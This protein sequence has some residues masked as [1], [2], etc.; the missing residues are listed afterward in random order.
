[1]VGV[2]VNLA[3]R[4]APNDEQFLY[5]T[6]TDNNGNWV[7]G[8][9]ADNFRLSDGKT[10]HQISSFSSSKESVSVGLLIDTSGSSAKLMD[11]ANA[12]LASFVNGAAKGTEFFVMTF[13]VNPR[14]LLDRTTDREEV[15]RILRTAAAITPA[16][17][18]AIFDA[19]S[20][21]VDRLGTA[22]N[23]KRVLMVFSDGT[24]NSSKLS[25][26]ALRRK[27]RRSDVLVYNLNRMD[28]RYAASM[29]AQQGIAF[30]DDLTAQTGGRAM[31]LK[32]R[33]ELLEASVKTAEELGNQYRIGFR[34]ADA[35]PNLRADDW[36]NLEL[37]LQIPEGQKKKVG[38]LYVRARR[39]F[40]TSPGSVK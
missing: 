30:M 5:V 34:P 12:G 25:Y 18:T 1:M 13:D 27:L 40:Y 8:L 15:L 24:D 38:K 35:N 2:R 7:G 33:T 23:S 29:L 10:V 17:N 26:E 14:M 37:K 28:E 20:V 6:V 39:G 4:L 11:D 22:Q 3:Q 19:I 32:D 31:Y 36:R 9:T 16:K 21:A